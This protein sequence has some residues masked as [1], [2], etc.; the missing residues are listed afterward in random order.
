MQVPRPATFREARDRGLLVNAWLNGRG[1]Y[2]FAI[3]T[4]A[5]ATLVSQRLVLEAGLPVRAGRRTL[6]GGLSGFGSISDREATIHQIALGERENLLP[7]ESRAVIAPSLPAGLD[8]IL[9]PT[10]AYHPLGYSIDLP[11]RRIEAFDPHINPLST[12]QQPP[13]GTVVRWAREA[14][15]K[16]PFVRLADGRLALVDT[17]SGFGF[18][19]SEPRMAAV[20]K[21][22]A[23]V[24]DL[25]GATIHSRR[26]APTEVT[27]G[28]LVLRGLPTDVLSGT[29]KGAPTILGRDALYPFRITFDP[30]KWLIEFAPMV[31][32]SR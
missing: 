18:A 15:T 5:G 30:L 4:G 17:G 7:S 6:L 31:E 1:P 13:G 25:S 9:D 8:G 28:S 10:Q 21:S 22:H 14:G 3:D 12:A 32:D 26:V 27:I 23:G 11:R 2:T 24:R 16:R 20:S 29:E 19:V